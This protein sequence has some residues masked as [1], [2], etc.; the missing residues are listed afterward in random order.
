MKKILALILCVSMVTCIF[1]APV[2]VNAVTTDVLEPGDIAKIIINTNTTNKIEAEMDDGDVSCEFHCSLELR[3]LRVRPVALVE[4][5]CARAAEIAD[6]IAISQKSLE[7]RRIGVI[8]P[9]LYTGAIGHAVSYACHL[10]RFLL[11]VH[12]DAAE[13]EKC[14]NES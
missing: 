7:L 6:H 2:S 11:P 10:I 8:F 9:I 14:G 12:G 1:A 5:G 4:Q 3:L 13:Q